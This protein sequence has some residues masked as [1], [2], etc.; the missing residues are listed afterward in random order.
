V[1]GLENGDPWALFG[2]GPRDLPLT[3]KR[4]GRPQLSNVGYLYDGPSRTALISVTDGRAK[5]HNLRR[6]PRASLHVTTPNPGA[7]VVDQLVE[8]Y[9]VLQG[10]HPD[11]ADFRAAMVCERRLLRLPLTYAYG[12]D[13][14]G[15]TGV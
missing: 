14:E 9:L 5:S 2:T 7:Y 15:H 10:D 8:H 3:L 11:W 4:D 12:W 6:D 13:P 1:T